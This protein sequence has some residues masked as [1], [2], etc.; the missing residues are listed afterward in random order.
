MT[1]RTAT[2]IGSVDQNLTPHHPPTPKPTTGRPPLLGARG[3]GA[4]RAGPLQPR[5][6][7]HRA[8][9]GR[10]RG[11]PAGGS[12]GGC[13]ETLDFVFYGSTHLF[14][15]I[16]SL[17]AHDD[18]RVPTKINHTTAPTIPGIADMAPTA[19]DPQAR[20]AAMLVYGDQV[21]S[22]LVFG[23]VGRA[24]ETNKTTKS[25]NQTNHNS[26]PSSPSTVRRSRGASA[27]CSWRPI[28]STPT[29]AAICCTAR[30]SHHAR[31]SRR[32]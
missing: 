1:D 23:W 32:R 4:L 20:C 28:R 8:G 7:R 9:L 17:Q 15:Q 27:G 12:A 11:P 10:A 18:P 30:A 5:A 13:V 24:P 16:R 22:G 3:R 31:R 21:R 29:S 6:R 2:K 19:M 26:W 25:T 14:I